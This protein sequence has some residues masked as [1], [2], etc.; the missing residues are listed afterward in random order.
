[1]PI[2]CTEQTPHL[3]VRS[4]HS[5]VSASTASSVPCIA[6]NARQA[7]LHEAPPP[8]TAGAFRTSSWC[9]ATGL[10][11]R[12]RYLKPPPCRLLSGR[13][14][15]R[16]TAVPSQGCFVPS[17]TE[18]GL[19]GYCKIRPWLQKMRIAVQR[20]MLPRDLESSRSRS[21]LFWQPDGLSF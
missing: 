5:S 15:L 13:P 2:G 16:A 4:C 21:G 20:N 3:Q 18:I 10:R 9:N 7:R 12:E 19:P 17:L 8:S 11:P 6:R 14:P 1:M